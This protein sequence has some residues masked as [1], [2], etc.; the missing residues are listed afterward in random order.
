MSQTKLR[1]DQSVSFPTDYSYWW[2]V[3]SLSALSDGASVATWPDS[4]GNGRDATEATNPP[5]YKTNIIEGRLPVVRF[6]GPGT[7]QQLTFPDVSAYGD[8]C[9]IVVLCAPRGLGSAQGQ[10]TLLCGLGA[11]GLHFRGYGSTNWG[12]VDTS[13][14]NYDSGENLQVGQ[15]AL[16]FL[17]C[18]GY[19]GKYEAGR[20]LGTRLSGSINL[21]SQAQNGMGI[22]G[23]HPAFSNAMFN[24][25]MAEILIYPRYLSELE[26]C[27]V[28]N[29]L[30]AKY[31]SPTPIGTFAR[32]YTFDTTVEGWTV[33]AGTLTSTGGALR[34]VGSGDNFA[35]DPGSNIADGEIQCKA[36]IIAGS[37][38]GIAFRVTDS[39]NLY[40]FVLR[41]SGGNP[42]EL[43]ARVSGGYTSLATC[44]IS[45]FPSAGS[46][47]RKV[48][49]R[50]KGSSI[51]LYLGNNPVPVLSAIDT[52]FTT[53]TFGLRGD[54]ANT[55]EIDD[56]NIYSL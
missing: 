50:F 22:I 26:Y 46:P 18:Q 8:P 12:V 47:F 24:G 56:V 5:V 14:T 4:S 54:R 40:L 11:C 31:F 10:D 55:A 37:E 41:N 1:T 29:Y 2:K 30:A 43:Y 20:G 44:N 21:S 3:S 53:G 13:G 9:T 32:A 42:A 33:G 16:M 23:R 49:I 39:N 51:N 28:Y 19:Q 35:I 17:R 45:P 52:T 15:W 25:D 48:T 7:S 34:L 6:A 27:A 38:M 36:R